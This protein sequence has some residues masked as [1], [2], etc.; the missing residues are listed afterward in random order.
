MEA[1]LVF[2]YFRK[3]RKRLN[4]SVNSSKAKMLLV[5]LIFNIFTWGDKGYGFL[6]LPH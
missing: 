3:S 5:P 6:H 4:R 1:Q 2:V